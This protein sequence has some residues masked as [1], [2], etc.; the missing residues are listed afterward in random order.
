MRGCEQLAMCTMYKTS[1]LYN[2]FSLQT[3]TVNEE[4][5]AVEENFSNIAPEAHDHAQSHTFETWQ[6]SGGTASYSGDDH[7]MRHIL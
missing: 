2:C 4:S 7:L 3:H 5:E 1:Y 6:V